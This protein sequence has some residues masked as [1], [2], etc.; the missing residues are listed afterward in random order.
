MKKSFIIL[1]LLSGIVHGEALSISEIMYDPEGSDTSREW[2]EVYNDTNSPINLTTWKFFESGTNHGMTSYSGGTSFPSLGYAIV[3]DNPLKF[4][5][6]FP[7]YQGVLYDST[8]SLSNSGEHIA[9]KESSSGPEICSV[10]YN[11]SLGGNNDGSTLSTVDGVWVKSD[12]T[13][14]KE[15]QIASQDL[16]SSS[17]STSTTTNTQATV[18]Q[19]SAPTADVVLYMPSEKIAI[20][21]AETQFS[22][23]GLT[24]RG[25]TI[26]NLTYTWAYGDG[27]EGTGSTTLYRY[28]YPGRYITQVEGNN[29]YVMG[30]GRINVRVVSPDI[31]ITK[32]ENGKY[33]AFVDVANPNV[34]DL[35]LSQWKL[36]I[37]NKI[38]SFPKNTLIQGKGVTHFSG[39]AMGFASTTISSSTVVKILFPNQEEVV[40]YQYEKK[41]IAALSAI[42]VQPTIYQITSTQKATLNNVKS[43]VVLKNQTPKLN[44]ASSSGGFLYKKETNRDTRIITF[45]KSIFGGKH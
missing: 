45:F 29:G 12:A 32:I 8:F 20:A 18:A 6:D 35:D 21:G 27:G 15:N 10:D 1:L 37:D 5:E 36:A 7:S 41:E 33:G 44:V 19:M 4:L 13:P 14:G 17:S 42:A 3:A 11:T 40:R 24:R 9:F 28:A 26:N 43:V 22:T 34:Y 31:A 25:D 30:V 39:L 2:V 16:N 23:F 38:F